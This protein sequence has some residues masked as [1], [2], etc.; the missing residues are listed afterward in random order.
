M[1]RLLATLFSLFLA[2]A[3]VTLFT[4][5]A[6][7]DACSG[8]DGV[9]VV[10]QTADDT[11]VECAK[12]DPKSGAEALEKAGF[13][14]TRVT[15]KP[16]FICKIGGE[17]ADAD[18]SKMAPA[19][20]FWAYFQGGADGKWAFSQKGADQYDPAPGSV[21]GWR[22]GKGDAPT[23]SPADA[24]KAVDKDADDSKKADADKADEDSSKGWL[25]ALPV[26][27][28]LLVGGGVVTARR[29]RNRS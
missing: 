16:D 20:A 22:I 24:A 21:E 8:K 11:E 13:E 18:C 27:V 15:G 7:A 10:V 4:A 26:I 29:S 14:L 12:G 1:H 2:V 28:I 17:P 25:W 6:Q 5:P 9:T 3:G 23:T 19:T